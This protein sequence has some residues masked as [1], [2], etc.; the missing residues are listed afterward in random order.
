MREGGCSYLLPRQ[1]PNSS[2]LPA[3]QSGCNKGSSG[4]RTCLFD[5][6]RNDG[7]R[8]LQRGS[9]RCAT[10]MRYGYGCSPLQLEKA[11]PGR[12]DGVEV[13]HQIGPQKAPASRTLLF[14]T[15]FARPPALE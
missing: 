11:A 9:P 1:P 5:G 3:R 8:G 14:S 4:Q 10:C 6:E 7:R 2:S 13:S 12:G 15:R